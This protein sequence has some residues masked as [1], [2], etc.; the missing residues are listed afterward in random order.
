MVTAM[1]TTADKDQLVHPAN[2]VHRDSRDSKVHQ[3]TPVRCLTAHR[4]DRR[5][6]PAGWADA[7]C[8]DNRDWMEIGVRPAYEDTA[9]RLENGRE[10]M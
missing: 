1:G 4:P 9:D 2:A 7:V 8:L 10:E 6:R 5:A 3:A